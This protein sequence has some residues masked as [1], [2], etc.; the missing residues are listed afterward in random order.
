MLHGEAEGEEFLV[1][2]P[3]DETRIHR[4]HRIFGKEGGFTRRDVIFM[5][6]KK[7]NYAFVCF[8]SAFRNGIWLVPFA[9]PAFCILTL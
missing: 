8:L 7:E 9:Q 1:L 2:F 3:R 4:F 6:K 5:K